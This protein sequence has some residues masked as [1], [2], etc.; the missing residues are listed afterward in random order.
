MALGLKRDGTGG[1]VEEDLSKALGISPEGIRELERE[2]SQ[3]LRN[4]Q[5]DERK[6]RYVIANILV[7]HLTH[8]E[9]M[10]ALHM[11]YAAPV[12]P[13]TGEKLCRLQKRVQRKLRQL[14]EQEL[15]SLW[16][17]L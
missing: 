9:R 6:R 4:D 7:T 2:L 12:A 14:P 15:E 10:C 13:C 1:I 8:E 11:F 5:T 16:H 17:L 3:L